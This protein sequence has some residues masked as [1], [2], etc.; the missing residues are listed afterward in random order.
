[1]T[2]T[3]PFVM[4]WYDS[5]NVDVQ[6]KWED[7]IRETRELNPLMYQTQI[8][9]LQNMYPEVRSF[10]VKFSDLQLFDPDFADYLLHS[11]TRVLKACEHVLCTEYK[12]AMQSNDF[13]PT[14]RIYGLPRDVTVGIRHLRHDSVGRIVAIE[15]LVRKASEVR[16]KITNAVFEC[17]RCSAK[18]KVAQD[19]DSIEEPMECDPN[20]GGCSR[21]TSKTKFKL[22]R[23]DSETKDVQILEIQENTEGLRGGSQA[24]RIKCILE[25]DLTDDRARVCP[26][27]RVTFNGIIGVAPLSKNSTTNELVLRVNSVTYSKHEYEQIEI[28]PE[29][30][31]EILEVAKKEDVLLE[32]SKA[33]APSVWGYDVEK[34]AVCLQLFGGQHGTRSDGTR[35]RGD[36]HILLAGDPGVAK[37]LFLTSMK[38]L[39]PRTIFATGGASSGVGLTAATVKDENGRWTLEAGALV[40][41]DKGL[42][43][44]DEMDKMD[45]SDAG[46]IHEAMESQT[47]TITKAGLNATLQ[48]RCSILAALNPKY[49]RFDINE[50]LASQVDLTP[51]LLSRFDLI[52]ALR[53]VP[54]DDNDRHISEYIRKN[55]TGEN[56]K[57]QFT[58]DFIRK[59]VAYARSKIQMQMYTEE[60]GK[61]ADEF[62]LS[63]RKKSKDTGSISITPRQIEGIDRL[64][65]ASAKARLSATVEVQDVK[66]AIKI[67]DYYLKKLAMDDGKYDI[68]KLMTGTTTNQRV[69][70]EAI[71]G[72]IRV[73]N[74]G[75]GVSEDEIYTAFEPQMKRTDIDKAIERLRNHV[76]VQV[77]ESKGIYHPV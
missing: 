38:E 47:V 73:E 57:P 51:A 48:S 25:A 12:T 10:A 75:K 65:E 36:I 39:A 21:T 37:T 45:I 20:Q 9:D 50:P 43:C 74:D 13:A 71:A 1:M 55:R 58:T 30:E 63:M 70:L 53:D 64:S 42:C 2:E 32:I 5:S 67:V 76:P 8:N 22:L 4:D 14:V 46:A 54:N 6:S 3:A 60:A 59:Y 77:Y 29:D 44:I 56:V 61:Y 24:E 7:F 26:G 33:I 28:S 34:E 41:A 40:L 18:I 35:I 31:K 17:L 15:S 69:G 52:F 19:G 27:D 66:R 72:F 11:P 49:G 62:Y 68:D 23:D 16:P